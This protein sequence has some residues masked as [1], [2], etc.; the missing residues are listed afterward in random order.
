MAEF[1]PNCWNRLHGTNESEKKFILSK[2][3]ELC[4]GCGE[5]KRIVIVERRVV[6]MRI[7]YPIILL[8][9]LVYALW[10][11]LILPYLIY[12]YWKEHKKFPWT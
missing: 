5:Q 2:E 10:R 6:F 9:K 4:E 12:V 1:C 8:G 3:P 11:I 7:G